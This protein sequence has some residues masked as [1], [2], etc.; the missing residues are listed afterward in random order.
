MA[1]KIKPPRI[2]AL[3]PRTHPVFTPSTIP[4]IVK[5]EAKRPITMMGTKGAIY[6]K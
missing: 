5:S 1:I 2:W 3:F 4:K 6:S